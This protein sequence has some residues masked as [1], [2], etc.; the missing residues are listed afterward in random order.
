MPETVTVVIP[1]RTKTV[2]VSA[3]ATL[4][5][6]NGLLARVAA[7]EAGGGGGSMSA[8]AILA[9][10]LTV[11]GTSSGLDAD[12]LDG[13]QGT[14]Y[15]AASDLTALTS[16]VATLTTTVAGKQATINGAATTIA[17]LDLTASRAVVSNASGKIA[18]SAVTAAELAA[19]SGVTVV[20]TTTLNNGSLNAYLATVTIGGLTVNGATLIGGI[21]TV[22][23]AG[24]AD[25]R[26]LLAH[27]TA[28]DYTSG[29]TA[30]NSPTANT[31]LEHPGS[32][33]IIATREWCAVEFMPDLATS[34]LLDEIGATQGSVLY[35]GADG[36]YALAPGTAGQTLQTGGTGANP[37][38]ATPSGGGTPGGSD[39]QLQRNNGG[40]FGGISGVTSDGTNI[41]AGS[42]NLRATSPRI[43]TQISDANGNP[44]LRQT[45][46]ASAVYGAN[47]TNAVQGGTVIIAAQAPTAQSASVAGSGVSLRGASAV[48]GSSTAG[49]ANGGGVTLIA[50]AAARL[51]SGNGDGGS[52][53]ATAGNGVGQGS[54]G[55]ITLTAGAHGGTS[56]AGS[57]GSVS[58]VGGSSNTI[59]GGNVNLTSGAGVGVQ[60]NIVLTVPEVN[61]NGAGGG[62]IQLIGGYS[63]YTASVPMTGG[64][65]KLT[66][67]SGAGSSASATPGATGGAQLF[68]LGAGGANTFSSGTNTGGAGGAWTVTGGTGGAATGTGATHVGGA[69]SAISITAGTGGAAT[70]ASGTRTGGSGGSIALTSGPGG[71]GSTTNG[72]SGN[73]VIAT[74]APGAGA[75]AAGATG[76]IQIKPGGITR[77]EIKTDCIVAGMPVIFP[78]YTVATVPAAATYARSVIHVSDETG[79]PTNAQSDGTNWRRLYDNAIIS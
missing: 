7:L 39:T 26:I 78:P 16:T 59:Q 54:G 17:S 11:D 63:N 46:I 60:G 61:G 41:T 32:D 62:E 20:N 79:G 15:A 49:A 2:T 3:Y 36:W 71:A 14:Y 74:G 58:L 24:S 35:R 38:W 77:L 23:A 29:F 67:R 21:L 34:A 69:G 68:T 13:Q 12:K 18:V 64:P 33:G 9:A 50:G 76:T 42:D 57:A 40:A 10:L 66:T 51:T 1:D 22:G 28:A 72:A 4:S 44:W 45:A 75:G 73:F 30:P 52:I 43:T 56:G 55:N 6:F 19:L 37:S 65:I 25:G 8:A 27:G 31:L 5:A 70:S 48:A 47:F 53:S